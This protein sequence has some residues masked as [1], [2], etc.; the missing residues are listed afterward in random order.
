MPG[1]GFTLTSAPSNM[2]PM[3]RKPK[4]PNSD[5][6]VKNYS[7]GKVAE[8]AGVSVQ[9]VRVWERLGYVM[10]TRT[11]GG[12][13]VF[14]ET[15]LRQ[16]IAKAAANRRKRSEE[17]NRPVAVATSTELASTGARIRRARIGK[18]LSQAEAA[19]LI[20]ISRS[21]LAAA[22]RGE[23]GVSIQT[24]SRMADVFS[25]PMSK[26]ASAVD[27]SRRVMRVADRPRTVIGG[28]VIWEE[29]APPGSH[30]L[31]PALLHVPAG[32]TSGGFIVRP[33]DDFAFML[34]GGLNFE[35]GDTGETI[36]LAKG[37]ALI[38]TGGTPISWRNTGRSTATC[39]W[40]ELI[41]TLR[42]TSKP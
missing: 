35:F 5:D 2:V 36:A 12:H 20:G 11:S 32:Q 26:F 16:V 25:I 15:A 34:H 28:G 13:R 14:S 27:P 29:L 10:S 41:S 9:T 31:E 18:G 39:L 22:E 38:V 23:S 7:I 42:K 19:D 40:I 1:T 3:H 17:R 21:F 4:S 8:V 6:Q 37:N 24:L 30:D 33:G